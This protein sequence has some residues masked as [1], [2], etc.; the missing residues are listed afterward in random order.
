MAQDRTAL[1]RQLEQDA[2]VLSALAVAGK[3]SISEMEVN[4]KIRSGEIPAYRDGRRWLIPRR[5]FERYLRDR[6]HQAEA[7]TAR[8]RQGPMRDLITGYSRTKHARQ[9]T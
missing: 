5:L 6:E 3:L 8:R 4:R 2:D 7:E 1:R 9:A